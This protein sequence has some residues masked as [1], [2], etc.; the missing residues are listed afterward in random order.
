[1]VDAPELRLHSHSD[2]QVL[3][4]ARI[5]LGRSGASLPT[6][7]Q[8]AFML[9]HA[10]ARDAVHAPFDAGGIAAS[11]AEIGCDVAQVASRAE[12]RADY[13]RRPDFGRQLNHVSRDALARR[14][15][16]TCDIVIVIGDGLSAAAVHAHAV[17]LLSELF[18]RLKTM[19]PGPIVVATQARV[20]LGDEIG[21]LCRA[22]MSLVLIGERPGLT[23]PDSL[24][25]YVTCDPKPGRTDADRNCVSNIHRGGLSYHEAA[26]KIAWLMHAGLDRG[27]TGVMLKDESGQGL[28]AVAVSSSP[29]MLPGNSAATPP[30]A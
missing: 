3:T 4:P 1:M 22:R 16:P 14:D 7:A 20:A 21:V 12:T 28:G 30:K 2:L 15:A 25:A 6:A 11:V 5:A 18:P 19:R 24:G 10:R 9:D 8:L 23:A 29:T 26:R 17:P 13:L 27:M